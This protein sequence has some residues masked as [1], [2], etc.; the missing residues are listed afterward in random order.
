MLA[1]LATTLTNC[2]SNWRP[3]YFSNSSMALVKVIARRYGLSVVMASMV[4]AIMMIRAPIGMSSPDSP[5][6]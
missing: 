6:G 2:G 5:S 4:S 1:D 3:A